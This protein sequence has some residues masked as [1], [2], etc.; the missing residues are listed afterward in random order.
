MRQ[1]QAT[2]GGFSGRPQSVFAALDDATGILVVAAISEARPRREG[3]I[4]IHSDSRADRDGVFDPEEH[5]KDAIRAY[6]ALREDVAED[7]KSAKLRFSE[8]AMF[9]DPAGIIETD[10]FDARGPKYR[11]S[12]EARNAQVATLALCRFARLQQT[13][14]DVVEMAGT[15]DRLLRGEVVTL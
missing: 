6:Y 10:G 4:V 8:R 5:L 12:P 15:L 9:A 2:I 7:G 14:A 11:V 1:L 13:M 3:C